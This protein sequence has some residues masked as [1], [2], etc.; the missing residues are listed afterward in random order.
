MTKPSATDHTLFSR[1]R[2]DCCGRILL[3]LSV[4]WMRCVTTRGPS[5]PF[6][7]VLQ[8]PPVTVHITDG[9]GKRGGSSTQREARTVGNKAT[10]AA[11]ERML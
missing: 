5:T 2:G 10:L 6:L 4:V 8:V 7:K 9:I 3:V 1:S 11:L